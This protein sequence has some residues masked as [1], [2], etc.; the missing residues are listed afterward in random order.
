M[1]ISEYYS[2]NETPSGDINGSNK[3]FIANNTPNPV[4]SLEVFLNGSLRSRSEDYDIVAD[5]ITFV[6]APLTD[7]ILRICYRYK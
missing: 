5:T 3:I 2:D 6:S 7:S 1:L 4:G